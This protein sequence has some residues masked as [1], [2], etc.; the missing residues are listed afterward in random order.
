[1]RTIV[2]ALRHSTKFACAL[3]ALA[4]PLARV[5]GADAP[6]DADAFPTFESYVKVSGQAP[7]ITGDRA[8]FATRTGTP[9]SD[10]AFGIEDLFYTKDLNDKETVKVTGHAMDGSDDYLAN[11]N[12]SNSD[13]GSVDAGY[14]RFRTFYDGVGGFFPLTD[15]FEKSS[16]ENLHVD[17]SSFWIDLKLA[18]PDAP[19]FTLSYHDEMRT[20]EK[21]STIWAAIINPNANVSGAGALVGTAAPANT[22]FISPNILSLAEHHNILDGSV[23]A[24]VG[25]TTETLRGVLDWVNNLDTRYYTKYPNSKV[26]V[27]PTVNVVDDQEN[28]KAKT[29]RVTN[30]TETEITDTLGIDTGLSFVHMTGGDGGIWIT[31]AYSSSAKA[32]YPA[33]TA[34]NIVANAQENDYV[35]NIFLKYA[36]KNWMAEVGIRDESNVNSDVGGFTST[37]LSS[38]ATTTAATNVNTAQNVTYSHMIDHVVTPDASL[39]FTGISKLA[40]YASFNKQSTRGTQH[41]VNPY[42]A[43]TT[44]GAGVVTTSL[45]PISSTFFQDANQDYENGKVGADWYPNPIITIRA[46]VFRKDHQNNFIGADDVVGTGSYGTLFATGYT[47]TGSNL[48]LILKVRPDLSFTTRYQPQGGNIAVTSNA[49]SGG[50]GTENPSGKARSQLI[51]ETVNWNPIKQFYAQ[52]SINIAYNYIQTAYPTV[53]VNTTAPLIPTP[54]VNSDDNYV[55]G[56]ALAGFVVDK[57]TDAQVQL[58]WQQAT[59]YNPQVALGGQPYGASFLY[60][61]AT[62]GLKHKFSDRIIGDCK[63][64]YLRSTDGTTGGFTNYHGPLGYLSITYS[65]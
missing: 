13:Y 59:D 21:D 16:P 36:P 51:S 38:T 41:W 40:L 62:L 1:M 50:T 44:S 9:N 46:E 64:G 11:V 35:G 60:E 14:K 4:L 37:S 63:I 25:K 23:T 18:R 3:A 28:I 39:S 29:L 2:T 26:V 42:A 7:F 12:F 24:T 48:S 52:A 65:L 27:D 19:V 6:A 10:G 15:T 53:V 43:T 32:V 8:A 56:T 34:G 22:P 17:R 58:T 47:F 33:I 30:Q 45:A 20:G 31:P 49:A 55:T 54:I 5:A 57:A 61:S